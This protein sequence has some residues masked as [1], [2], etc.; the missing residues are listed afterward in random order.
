MKF[1][2]KIFIL[3]MS[4]YIVSLAI[5]GIVVTEYSYNS[6]LKKE[7][8][9]SLEEES[10]LHSTLALYL[11]N[12]KRIT[13]EKIELEKYSQSMVDM[14]KTDNNYLEVFDKKMNLLASNADKNWLMTREELKIALEGKKNFILR[15]DGGK[16]YLFMANVLQIED[17]TI[18]LSLIKDI[19][20]I[21]NQRKEQYL[22]FL[23]T[24]IIGLIFVAAVT[25]LLSKLVIRPILD[26]SRTA[27]N[28]SSGNFTDR[29]KVNSKDEI[30][31]LAQQF[32]IMAS[33]VEAKISE[34]EKESERQRR[35]I[36]NLTHELRTPLTSIIGY[37]E[38]LKTLQYNPDI[39]NKGLNY[40]HGEGKRMLKLSNTLMDMIL[41]REKVFQLEK[42][43]VLPLL[44]E[45]KDILEVK[46][47]D[48]NIDLEII[49]EDTSILIDRDLFKGVLINLVDNAL[50]ASQN[51]MIIYLGVNKSRGR[52]HVYVQD[53]GCGMEKEEIKKI[54]EPF[55]RVEK[56]RSRR[57]GGVGLGLAICQQ[58]V[59][60][61]GATLEVESEINKGT[62]VS[63]IFN[64][65]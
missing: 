12:N 56:S 30:G 32:N 29:V 1:G 55:Y 47:I 41:L 31:L 51:G 20:H 43:D 7:V 38:L 59:I 61:H 36:D 19:T 49:G 3:C 16:H 62:K 64:S 5:T 23:R 48:K 6:L 39:Y 28:I 13:K 11:L 24:G 22:F 18:I 17:E 35:F 40:I 44:R 37:A 34:L 53:E 33:E 65:L 50:K 54:I 15:S 10:N 4:I 25:F 45:V 9:R 63:I 52:T 8:Q 58:I 57:E 42:Q 14:F 21:D 27:H 60:D 46:A 26:L 2:W